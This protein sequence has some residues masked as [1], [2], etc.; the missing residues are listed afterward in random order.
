MFDFEEEML[1]RDVISCDN[2]DIKTRDICVNLLL[3]T[4]EMSD[5][6]YILPDKTS[7]KYKIY[8]L[9]LISDGYKILFN[10]IVFNLN[11]NRFIDGEIYRKQNK[12]YVSMNIARLNLCIEEDNKDF[13]T[14]DIFNVKEDHILR[15]TG[16][17]Q[18]GTY[19]EEELP[20]FDDNK[21]Y[22]E[23]KLMIK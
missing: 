4:K 1:L 3:N 2:M 15:K 23:Y 13:S 11:E 17:A 22:D 6:E 12:Y 14:C 18:T 10:G 21:L 7:E 19:F 9:N 8:G 20:L 5:S 16:Y